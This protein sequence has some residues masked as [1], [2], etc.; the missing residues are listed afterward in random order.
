MQNK[1]YVFGDQSQECQAA[2]IAYTCSCMGDS[3][4]RA[5]NQSIMTNNCGYCSCYKSRKY[6]GGDDQLAGGMACLKKGLP[7]TGRGRTYGD[8]NLTSFD[9]V[10]IADN[11]A[12][13]FVGVRR[14]AGQDSPPVEVHF[15]YEPWGGSQVV[16]QVTAVAVKAGSTRVAVYAGSPPTIRV[17]GDVVEVPEEGF[18]AND[19]IDVYAMGAGY[20][21]IALPSGDVL[22]VT[23]VGA[24]LNVSVE[25]TEEQLGHVEG[26]LGLWDQDVSDEPWQWGPNQFRVTSQADSLFDYA[27]G[28]SFATYDDPGF[29][30]MNWGPPGGPSPMVAQAA[31]AQ[32]AGAG[33][34]DPNV[35]DGCVHDMTATNLE[36]PEFVVA[37]AAMDL[38]I[39]GLSPLDAIPPEMNADPGAGAG[40]G[41]A[42]AGGAPSTMSGTTTS[43]MSGTTSSTTSSMMFG[44][45]GFPSP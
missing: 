7:R 4:A 41:G 24:M 16:S 38:E 19:F 10:R 26:V 12:G 42:G 25:L 39:S 43:T 27:A 40:S 1:C 34:V 11:R 36:A 13:E 28:E 5:T 35:L 45:G 9:G 18:A 3:N 22:T 44:M 15:R 17:N 33:I 8:P 2:K 37:A 29:P 20:T 23:G 6:T 21:S 14:I 32:C 30:H 31:L